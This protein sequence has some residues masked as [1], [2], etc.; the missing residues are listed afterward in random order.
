MSAV[1]SQP[2]NQR[3]KPPG[4]AL[5]A[6]QAQRTG[7]AGEEKG[8]E[9]EDTLLLLLLLQRQRGVPSLDLGH[10]GGKRRAEAAPGSAFAAVA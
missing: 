10:L 7:F 4:V 2:K 1:R 6:R 9:D 8:D 5:T 3:V